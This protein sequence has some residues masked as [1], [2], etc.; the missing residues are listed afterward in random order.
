MVL[1]AGKGHETQQQ[2]ADRTVSFDDRNQARIALQE[3]PTTE[4][5]RE[6]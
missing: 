4:G 2:F 6:S 5:R 1:I 3:R